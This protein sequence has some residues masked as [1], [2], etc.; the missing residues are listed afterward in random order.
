[1]GQQCV[2]GVGLLMACTAGGCVLQQCMPYSA[3]QLLCIIQGAAKQL[4]HDMSV[5]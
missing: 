1:M 3:V 4:R 2:F 5:V